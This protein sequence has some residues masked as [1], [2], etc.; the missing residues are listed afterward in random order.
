MPKLF[1]RLLFVLSALCFILA[2]VVSLFALT[3]KTPKTTAPHQNSVQKTALLPTKIILK[4]ISIAPLASPTATPTPT[5]VLPSPFPTQKIQ[6]PIPSGWL[7]FKPGHNSITY[8]VYAPKDSK[9]EVICG[10]TCTTELSSPDFRME[11]YSGVVSGYLVRITA[12]NDFE[13]FTINNIQYSEEMKGEVP[14]TVLGNK[15]SQTSFPSNKLGTVYE[16]VY[17]VTPT[18]LEEDSEELA[19]V[20]QT[21][22]WARS[23]SGELVVIDFIYNPFDPKFTQYKSVFQ[24]MV[25]T[26]EIP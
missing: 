5:Y 2:F 13:A 3:Y 25:K 15:I 20:E 7:I 1:A 12:Y 8:S 14:G 21:T 11:P 9:Q 19:S 26:L 16:Y 4:T 17:S 6:F 10:G 23:K 22:A 24:N 18:Q